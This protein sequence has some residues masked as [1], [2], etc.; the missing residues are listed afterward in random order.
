MFFAEGITVVRNGEVLA[1]GEIV[2][3]GDLLTV[4]A[5]VPYGMTLTINGDPVLS[6]VTFPVGRNNVGIEFA[7]MPG[8]TDPDDT[9]VSTEETDPSDTTVSTEETDPSDT[10]VSTEETDPS[11]TAVTTDNTRPSDTA[12]TTDNTLPSDTA[13]TTDITYPSDT[14]ASGTE[15]SSVTSITIPSG[16]SSS[17]TSGTSITSGTAPSVTAPSVTSYTPPYIITGPITSPTGYYPPVIDIPPQRPAVTGGNTGSKETQSVN[18]KDTQTN[19][20]EAVSD[21]ILA[22][23]GAVTE[24]SGVKLFCELSKLGRGKARMMTR[25]SFFDDPSDIRLVH[26]RAAN[27]DALEAADIIDED[28]LMLYPFDLSIYKAGTGVKTQ[29][30]DGG[31]ISF[32]IPVPRPMREAVK[33]FKVYC[34]EG[35]VP[36]LIP[37]ELIEDENGNLKAVFTAYRCGNYMFSVCGE[38]ISSVAGISAEGV[39]TD[40]GIPAANGRMPEA[41]L[42]FGKRHRRKHIYY[43]KHRTQ[44]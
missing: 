2:A 20:E 14:T 1:N 24:D 39:A 40:M 22:I 4:T 25:L 16:S 42:P 23:F 27:E 32:E 31:Y 43:I 12:V 19:D 44:S 18:D 17:E 33:S 34:I 11:D 30:A 28:H 10:T 9:T 21:G 6:G 5:D 7:Q 36:E 35:G 29:I 38:D 15:E 3:S 8:F 26:T 37:H 13:V 41:M